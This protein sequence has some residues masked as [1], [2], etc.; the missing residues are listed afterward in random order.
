MLQTL[1][2]N[3]FI[4]SRISF[5]FSYT[6]LFSFNLIILILFYLSIN[7]SIKLLWCFLILVNYIFFHIFSSVHVLAYLFSFNNFPCI[8]P[9]LYSSHTF[10]WTIFFPLLSFALE[11]ERIP[12]LLVCISSGRDRISLAR[13]LI[14]SFSSIQFHWKL[15]CN[16]VWYYINPSFLFIWFLLFVFHFFLHLNF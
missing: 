7:K 16:I 4:T 14:P 2:G 9:F 10:H 6:Y 15:H 5:V 8:I 3:L 11:M 12:W 13:P 1:S